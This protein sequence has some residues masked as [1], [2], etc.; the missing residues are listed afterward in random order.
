VILESDFL[1]LNGLLVNEKGYLINELTGAIRSR[2]T[3][4]DLFLPENGGIEDIGEL[5]M[6]FRLEKY[7]F[8]PHKIS[9]HFEWKKKKKRNEIVINAA[10]QRFDK[11]GRPVNECGYLIN[12]RDDIIDNAGH[13]KLA[14]QLLGTN[15]K[16]PTLLNYRGDSYEMADIIGRF[17]KDDLSKEIVLKSNGKQATDLEGRLVNPAG[18]LIDTKGN[19]VDKHG[20]LIFH[21]W[22]VMFNEPPKF[23]AFTE[24][25]IN[26]IKGSLDKDVTQ[27]PDH[28]DEFDLLGRR[29]NTLGYLVDERD[30]IVDQHGREVFSTELLT[31]MYGMDA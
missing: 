31:N 9:G 8:N 13:V 6:P 10:G 18:Y 1:D 25:N 17:E 14:R 19:I 23:F 3:Y 30:N 28:D 11:H 2:Y 12:E 15:G 20:K 21:F 24:F 22:E 4:D 7:N 16:L 26:W 29:I 27:N 5:P